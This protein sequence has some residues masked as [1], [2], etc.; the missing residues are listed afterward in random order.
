MARVQAVLE[1]QHLRM[2]V[3]LVPPQLAVVGLPVPAPRQGRQCRL[4]LPLA[5]PPLVLVLAV[6]LRAVLVL[7][8]GRRQRRRRLLARRRKAKERRRDR[9][10]FLRRR[11]GV[12]QRRPIPDR[13]RPRQDQ[14]LQLDL[15]AQRKHA[16]FRRSRLKARCRRRV[17]FRVVAEPTLPPGAGAR[18]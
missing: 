3:A 1:R 10:Q 5:G 12:G 6:P 14:D 13:H 4:F 9:R 8:L 16:S 7:R 11:V 2:E 18:G 15:L 17:R